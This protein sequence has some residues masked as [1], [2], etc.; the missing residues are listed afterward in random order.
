M[1]K[2]R[3]KGTKKEAMK[4]FNTEKSVLT[5]SDQEQEVESNVCFVRIAANIQKMT[6]VIACNRNQR[7]FSTV[8]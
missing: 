5:K 6:Q 1:I 3:I 8:K 4:L 2:H 7:F